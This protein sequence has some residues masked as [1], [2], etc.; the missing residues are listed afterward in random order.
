MDQK[1]T[2]LPTIWSLLGPQLLTV[3][4]ALGTSDCML[5]RLASPLFKLGS[6]LVFAVNGCCWSG[7]QRHARWFLRTLLEDSPHG[8]DMQC[9]TVLQN[10]H[11][12]AMEE[13]RLPRVLHIGADN[14]PKETKN[15]TMLN[16]SVWLLCILSSTCL[17][18]IHFGFLMV[19]H[20]HDSLDRFFSRL[21]GALKGRDYFTAAEMQHL[22]NESMPCQSI[23][24]GHLCTSWNFTDLRAK[25]G[26]EAKKLRNVHDLKLFRDATGIFAQWKQWL[27]DETYSRPVLLVPSDQMAAIADTCPVPI[28]HKFPPLQHSQITSWLQKL[29][30]H[31]QATGQA[32]ECRQ[33]MDWLHAVVNQRADIQQQGLP[34]SCIISDLQHLSGAVSSQRQLPRSSFPDDLLAQLHPGADVSGTPVNLLMEVSSPFVPKL[35]SAAKVV[36]PGTFVLVKEESSAKTVLPFLMACIVDLLCQDEAVVQWYVPLESKEVNFRAGRK[37]ARQTILCLLV[38]V[39]D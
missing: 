28:P 23:A 11:C 31:L 24:W 25:I 15:S 4:L 34:I 8:A 1:K 26:L 32:D 20:T 13:G 14:T 17:W 27:T 30:M 6:R 39:I 37:K 36:G 9:S 21:C 29:H 2:V 19:G 35:A 5:P 16:F 33:R 38:T 10:L 3:A 22:V 12:A 18:Q 7:P